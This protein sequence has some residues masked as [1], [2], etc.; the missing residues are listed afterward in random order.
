[1]TTDDVCGV[2]VI[3]PVGAVDAALDRQVEAVLAQESE[4]PFDLVL[5]LNLRGPES[6]AALRSRWTIPPGRSLRVVEALD[7]RSAAHARN[8]GARAAG[9]ELL[10][11][12]DAD[13]LVHPGWLQA[14]VDA[15]GS[16]DAVTGQV[17]DVFPDERTASWHPPAT[18]GELPRFLGRP[19]LLSG[20]L[21]VRRAAFDAVGGFDETLTRCED[22]A[23]GWALTGAGFAI[24][25]APAAVLSYHHRSG[26]RSMLRQHYLYGRGMSETLARYGV[27]TGNESEPITA[28]GMLR[29][30]GQRAAKTTVGGTARRGAIALG[31]VRGIV[32]MRISAV[33][34]TPAAR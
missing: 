27:P 28:V 22:I 4:V 18:P 2:S 31:R 14:L 34:R 7:R 23:F 29:P 20:N 17:V 24:G 3:I 6:P 11:F 15:L 13:D 10:A 30:N 33:G 16:Y 25:Y 19:Y 1:M 32:G 12:C 8:V 26:M 5:S 21:A 9:G